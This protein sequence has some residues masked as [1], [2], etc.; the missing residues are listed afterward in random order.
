MN[1]SDTLEFLFSRR[2]MGMKYGLERITNLL[3]DAGNP[4]NS[5][6]TIHVVGTNGKGSTT[7]F[8]SE[9]L[10]HLNYRVGRFTSPH[11]L[12]YRERIAVNNIWIPK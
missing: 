5:F 7:A 4:Q 6:K 8:L 3:E 12:D 10:M 2:R 11:L 9:I 1:Y